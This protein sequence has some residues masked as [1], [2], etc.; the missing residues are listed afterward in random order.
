[1]IARLLAAI[2]GGVL[3][4]ILERPLISALSALAGAWGM[5]LGAFRLFGWHHVPAGS[6]KPPASYGVM[7]ACWLVIALIGAGIQLR[8]GHRRKKS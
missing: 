2:A 5:V 1:M 7:I 3:T 6:L 4:L 8:S